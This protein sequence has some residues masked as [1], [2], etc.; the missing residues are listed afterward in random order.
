[1]KFILFIMSLT[2]VT[3]D[4]HSNPFDKLK[5]IE[6][7]VKDIGKPNKKDKKKNY[8]KDDCQPTGTLSGSTHNKSLGISDYCEEQEKLEKE[9]KEE[10]RLRN[11]YSLFSDEGTEI[12]TEIETTYDDFG[13]ELKKESHYFTLEN[14]KY[15]VTVDCEYTNPYWFP[16]KIKTTFPKRLN[17][18]TDR[19][20]PLV[21]KIVVKYKLGSGTKGVTI[22]N[23]LS[24]IMDD[25]YTKIIQNKLN[26]F[27]ILGTYSDKSYPY[28]KDNKEQ[29]P[30]IVSYEEKKTS[31]SNGDISLVIPINKEDNYL[32][33]FNP[34]HRSWS[35]LHKTKCGV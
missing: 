17:H 27:T 13:D 3:T 4:I 32:I 2:L 26:N 28:N 12:I 18:I 31:K 8:N 10:D 24:V 11:F 23:Q 20:D 30:L 19:G 1:M 14:Q 22:L 5:E 35:D 34:F 21:G 9:K 15:F 16:Y 29:N 25:T 6:K 7:K 33:S